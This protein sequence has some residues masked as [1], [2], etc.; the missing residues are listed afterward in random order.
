MVGF[1]FRMITLTIVE[2]GWGAGGDRTS[3]RSGK[4]ARRQKHEM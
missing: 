3:I 1:A 2:N 4:L